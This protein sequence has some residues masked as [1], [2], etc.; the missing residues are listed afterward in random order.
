MSKDNNIFIFKANQVPPISITETPSPSP[1]VGAE[2]GARSKEAVGDVVTDS[3]HQQE[4]KPRPDLLVLP[5]IPVAQDTRRMRDG[6]VFISKEQFA[7]DKEFLKATMQRARA[8]I[9]TQLFGTTEVDSPTPALEKFWD[10]TGISKKK[11]LNEVVAIQLAR[12]RLDSGVQQVV[13]LQGG[14]TGL[15][16]PGRDLDGTRH[17]DLHSQQI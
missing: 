9:A 8:T 5:D 15:E 16:R 1:L 11:S 2:T 13:H 10:R 17:Q 14:I 6:Y 3:S 4:P 7:A 12:E